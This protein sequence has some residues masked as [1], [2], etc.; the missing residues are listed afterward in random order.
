[1][2]GLTERSFESEAETAIDLNYNL[3]Q[4]FNFR[5]DGLTWLIL[6]R[7]LKLGAQSWAMLR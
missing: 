5:Q 4:K 3:S 2:A 6:L 1:M 7:R